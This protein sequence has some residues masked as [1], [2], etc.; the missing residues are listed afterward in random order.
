MVICV[1]GTVRHK[2]LIISILRRVS[3]RTRPASLGGFFFAEYPPF[4][5]PDTH[6]SIALNPSR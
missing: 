6:P 5:A 2:I 1:D 3:D 4:A